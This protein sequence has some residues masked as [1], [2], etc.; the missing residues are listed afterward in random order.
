MIVLENNVKWS[1]HL[2]CF[3]FVR[4]KF[5]FSMLVGVLKLRSELH[6]NSTVMKIGPQYAA[7]TVCGYILRR[8]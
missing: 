4:K 5:R 6:I 3:A 7:Q 2:H 8:F 1:L